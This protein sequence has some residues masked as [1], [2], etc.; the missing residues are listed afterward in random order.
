MAPITDRLGVTV[1]VAAFAA[2]RVR[3]EAGEA[4]NAPAAD[5]ESPSAA[6]RRR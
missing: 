3:A 4:S 1:P 5:I 2:A 6:A